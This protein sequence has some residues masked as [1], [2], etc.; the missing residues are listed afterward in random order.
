MQTLAN[1]NH[2][3]NSFDYIVI[4]R[5]HLSVE[6]KMELRLAWI[7]GKSWS[8]QQPTLRDMSRRVNVILQ[9]LCL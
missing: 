2:R 9:Q 5:L 3:R 8:I 6:Y 1:Y 4:V 7:T